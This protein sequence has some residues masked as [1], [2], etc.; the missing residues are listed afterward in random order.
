MFKKC[1]LF[2]LALAVILAPTS[3]LALEL[4]AAAK[5]DI[6]V[7]LSLESESKLT[8]SLTAKAEVAENGQYKLLYA[9]ELNNQSLTAVDDVDVHVKMPANVKI[10]T[11]SVAEVEA[12]IT[13]TEE[14]LRISLPQIES[15]GTL[16][17]RLEALVETEQELEEITS[18]VAIEIATE[19]VFTAELIISLSSTS[20]EGSAVEEN[21]E[22][23]SP[24]DQPSEGS[25]PEEN[26]EEQAEVPAQDKQNNDQ[27][28]ELPKTGSSMGSWIWVAL[29][30]L[31][32]G[33]GVYLYRKSKV[34]IA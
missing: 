18:P 7:D 5:S 23:E 13:E 21:T 3:V 26:Q 20:E 15:N 19:E 11:Y 24:T 34:T 32:I 10:S 8:G 12:E 17:L 29:G 31:L 22:G 1:S 6:N 4:G 27:L 2:V 16:T 25:T 28:T 14:G 30:L 33:S 9:A